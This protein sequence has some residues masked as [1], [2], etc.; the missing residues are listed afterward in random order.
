MRITRTFIVV[1]LLALPASCSR[2]RTA[3]SDRSSSTPPTSKETVTKKVAPPPSDTGPTAAAAKPVDQ[4]TVQAVLKEIAGARS[5]KT[6]VS[7][8]TPEFLEAV[9]PQFEHWRG[10]L[11]SLSAA[12]QHDEADRICAAI[13]ELRDHWGTAIFPSDKF[14]AF[15][16]DRFE[17]GAFRV[18]AAQFFEPMS[19]HVG[20]DSIKKLLRFSV[21]QGEQVVK[22]YYL[23][24][25][26]MTD[27]PYYVLGRSDVATGKHQQVQPYGAQ[28]PSYWTLK[29]RMIADLLG[30]NAPAG[31]SSEPN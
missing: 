28:A 13:V 26:Q 15:G 19:F 29:E 6:K 31:P 24:R 16:R 22:R 18:D 20:D 9:A 30:T 7:Q 25:S 10:V 2:E 8:P 12:A 27:Q 17:M 11:T 23:E 5:W 14:N 21:Y 1:A 3:S 4:A